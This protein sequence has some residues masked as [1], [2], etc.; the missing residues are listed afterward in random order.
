LSNSEVIIGKDL[1][2]RNTWQSNSIQGIILFFEIF[3]RKNLVFNAPFFAQKLG[4]VVPDTVL[5]H[6]N[7]SFWFVVFPSL[8]LDEFKSRV[9]N[10]SGWSTY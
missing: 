3:V 7:Y 4:D 9:K 8:V 1:G 2:E 6:A 5:E 10:C